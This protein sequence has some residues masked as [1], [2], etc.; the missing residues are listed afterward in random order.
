MQP[1]NQIAP[2]PSIIVPLKEVCA[3]L[4]RE[5]KGIEETLRA[6]KQHPDVPEPRR[7][8]AA[9]PE[10]FPGQAGE[11]LAQAMLAV[12]HIEDA[13]MRVGKILQYA[14]DGVSILDKQVAP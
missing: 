8:G 10:K 9:V 7:P 3:N 1:E 13:R 14:D 2:A 6:L 4:R 5:L 11:M 12:R